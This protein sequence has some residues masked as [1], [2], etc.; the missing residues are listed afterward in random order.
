MIVQRTVEVFVKYE[1]NWDAFDR[2]ATPQE[3]LLLPDSSMREIEDIILHLS[4][5]KT[6]KVSPIYTAQTSALLGESSIEPSALSLLTSFLA[7][8]RGA[9]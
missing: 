5:A 1:G 3:R 6:G 7:Q 4:L 9:S 8:H 2:I